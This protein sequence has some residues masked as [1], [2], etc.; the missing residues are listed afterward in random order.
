MHLCLII[1]NAKTYGAYVLDMKIVSFF[2]LQL[3]F[4]KTRRNTSILFMCSKRY[5]AGFEVL[6]P[7]VMERIEQNIYF[8]SMNH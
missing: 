3:L 5:F 2:F 6:T 4:K 7:V 8:V 1:Y